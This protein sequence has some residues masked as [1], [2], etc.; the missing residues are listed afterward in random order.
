MEARLRIGGDACAC[1]FSPLQI[2]DVRAFLFALAGRLLA[3][4]ASAEEI[5]AL[6]EFNVVHAANPV[7]A[8]QY[9]SL[10]KQLQL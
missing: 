3:M 8:D 2:Y 5:V 10:I 9:L 7:L 1:G 4:R 6:H